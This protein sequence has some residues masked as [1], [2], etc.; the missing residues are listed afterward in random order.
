MTRRREWRE[1]RGEKKQKKWSRA[2]KWEE[3]R[4]AAISKALQRGLHAQPH[5]PF[6]YVSSGVCM[7]LHSNG[8]G[9][10]FGTV[11]RQTIA[12]SLSLMRTGV[13]VGSSAVPFPHPDGTTAG[14]NLRAW[15]LGGHAK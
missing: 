4:R 10:A 3:E 12:P 13:R 15:D 9:C 7:R 1:R 5:L 2:V 11:A 8:I 6:S 14:V